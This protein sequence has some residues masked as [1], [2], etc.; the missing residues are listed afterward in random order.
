MPKVLLLSETY[1][2]DNSVI[3]ENVDWKVI[4][5]VIVM[6]QDIYLEPILGTKMFQ[7][8]MAKADADITLASDP[9]YK[10]LVSDHI[11]PTLHYYLMKELALILKFRYMNKGVM[12]KSSDNS[13]NGDTNDLKVIADSHRITAEQYAERLTK[14]LRYNPSLYPLYFTNVNEDI[15]PIKK[16][17]TTGIDLGDDLYRHPDGNYYRHKYNGYDY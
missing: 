10:S 7:D 8:L 2:N 12:V 3:S 5:P 16:N 15:Q 11:V 13:Q 17:Y 6:A 4:Q 9:V 14:H 1:L